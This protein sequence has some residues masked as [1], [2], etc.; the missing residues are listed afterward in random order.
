MLLLWTLRV[1][2]CLPLPA[3]R[4]EKMWPQDSLM[5]QLLL[6]LQPTT[7]VSL[8]SMVT[9]KIQLIQT[10][11][12]RLVFSVFLSF[13]YPEP[14]EYYLYHIFIIYASLLPKQFMPGS[15][16]WPFSWFFLENVSAQ[17]SFSRGFLFSFFFC[18]SFYLFVTHQSL[19]GLASLESQHMNGFITSYLMVLLLHSI[20]GLPRALHW[21]LYCWTESCWSCHWSHMQKQNH[22]LC[23]NICNILHS[24]LW[25]G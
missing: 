11:W 23:V 1:W 16:K 20:S 13:S 14:T 8:P 7:V 12:K 21:V 24:G 15:S 4:L 2:S 6:R 10:G 17:G 19:S 5:V 3:T 18:H 22:C 25:P 9:P